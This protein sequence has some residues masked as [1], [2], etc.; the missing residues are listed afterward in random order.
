MKIVLELLFIHLWLI[1][2]VWDEL[3]KMKFPLTP[4][5]VLAPGSL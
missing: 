1:A 3:G 5:G 2:G 4:M